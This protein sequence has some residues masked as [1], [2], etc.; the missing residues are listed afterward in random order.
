LGE[1]TKRRGGRSALRRRS[2]SQPEASG[3]SGGWVWE[4]SCSHRAV[5][6]IGLSARLRLGPIGLSVLRASGLSTLGRSRW[7]RKGCVNVIR[8]M[9]QSVQ[10]C[11]ASPRGSLSESQERLGRCR[12][13][14]PSAPPRPSTS[15]HRGRGG[16]A[17]RHQDI[18]DGKE[19]SGIAGA[20]DTLA[21]R[22][23]PTWPTP[24]PPGTVGAGWPG[25]PAGPSRPTSRPPGGSG[26]RDQF[27]C[28][29]KSGGP[30]G[31][32]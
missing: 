31:N 29:L 19:G 2:G 17:G 3:A 11:S 6:P 22:S 13:F 16:R 27:R 30:G 1:E 28:I 18:D 21:G 8:P 5:N 7:P 4:P 10:P 15:L 20:T 23:L 32:G 9:G 24:G 26:H 14:G 25:L 12:P